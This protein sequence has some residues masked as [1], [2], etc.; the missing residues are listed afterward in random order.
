MRTSL[1]M[2]DALGLANSSMASRVPRPR[3]VTFRIEGSTHLNWPRLGSSSFAR[4]ITS[5][6]GAIYQVL[7]TTVFV[8]LVA[9][10]RRDLRHLLERRL[11][12]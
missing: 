1:R 7:D 11:L 9:D 5:R 8:M 3:S 12:G 4:P 10:G 6:T 2:M